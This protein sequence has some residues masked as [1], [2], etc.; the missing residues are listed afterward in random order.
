MRYE[1]TD[2]HRILQENDIPDLPE[3]T[4]EIINLL[5]SQVGAP[6]YIKTPQFKKSTTNNFNV[7]R[8]KKISDIQDDD[9][10]SIRQFH[11]TEFK[12]REG[13]EINLFQTRKSLN[14]LTNK[15]YDKIKESVFEQVTLVN[16]TK[17][18]NDLLKLA[19][20][21]FKISSNNTLYSHIYAT[22]FQELINNFPVFKTI[23]DNKVILLSSQFKNI[24][25]CNPDIDY[26]KFCENN[27]NNEQVRAQ[28]A[29]YCNLMKLDIIS[30][31]FIYN[32]IIELFT[33]MNEFIALNTKKNELDELSE[34][35]YILVCHSYKSI[36]N[37]NNLNYNTILDNI[38][39][40]KNMNIKDNPG[41]SNKYI[42]KHM[43]ILD[44]IQDL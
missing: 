41:I 29:F 5:A 25:Y 20:E 6:E 24:N 8:K 2:F 26:D 15:N 21:I 16:D 33:L 11:T 3:S 38:E 7:R 27:K 17:T 10:D 14:M 34:I 44:E 37:N 9:W 1:L 32:I 12:K 43:D 42:F 4:I 36:K 18:P 35:M 22:I 28:C 31:E 19:E 30:Q 23:L 13:L 40:I 39:K